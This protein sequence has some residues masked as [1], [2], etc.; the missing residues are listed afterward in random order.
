MESKEQFKSETLPILNKTEKKS[1]LKNTCFTEILD[2]DKIFLD[3][4]FYGDLIN[5]LI[6]ECGND[7]ESLRNRLSGFYIPFLQ[8]RFMEEK[9][10]IVVSIIKGINLDYLRFLLKDGVE[11]KLLMHFIKGIQKNLKGYQLKKFSNVPINW[12]TTFLVAS[13]LSTIF[14]MRTWILFE[15]TKTVK[16]LKS[17]LSFK[18]RGGFRCLRK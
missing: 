6:K 13:K 5:E 15:K 10:D 11:M 17:E 3:K 7:Q 9:S 2:L 1:I 18:Y 14:A 16:S 4:K 12:K 8:K